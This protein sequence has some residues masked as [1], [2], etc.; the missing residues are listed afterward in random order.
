M[1]TTTTG[2]TAT[3][4]TTTV[5]SRTGNVGNV[6]QTAATEMSKIATGVSGCRLNHDGSF[7]DPACHIAAI[8]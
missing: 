6:R 5:G 2:E 7:L 3:A 4:G 1:T 8:P